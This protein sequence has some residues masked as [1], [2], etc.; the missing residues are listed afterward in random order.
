MHSSVPGHTQNILIL[1]YCKIPCF[2]S[3]TLTDPLK[4]NSDCLWQPCSAT[5][6]KADFSLRPAAVFITSIGC[7]T[8]YLCPITMDE[9][10]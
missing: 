10:N 6:L 9:S 2:F 1:S 3:K 8:K 5:Y 7:S 4:I